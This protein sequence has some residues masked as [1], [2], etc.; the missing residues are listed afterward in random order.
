M[1]GWAEMCKSCSLY[2]VPPTISVSLIKTEVVPICK[3]QCSLHLISEYVHTCLC[4]RLNRACAQNSVSMTNARLD[5]AADLYSLILLL[6][7]STLAYLTPFMVKLIP[8][9]LCCLLFLLL[10]IFSSPKLQSPLLSQLVSFQLFFLPHQFLYFFR[11]SFLHF[12][13]PF[14]TSFHFSCLLSLVSKIS[15]TF[16]SNFSVF[17]CSPVSFPEVFLLVSVSWIS[18]FPLLTTFS[19]FPTC[20]SPFF[21]KISIC[22]QELPLPGPVP[23]SLCFPQLL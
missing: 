19:I 2:P 5:R 7:L 21:A 9:P 15:L 12:Y 16:S 1:G 22:P 10:P 4:P 17:S 14:K 18:F 23:M 20:M 8:F 11:F 6:A 13:H 3:A